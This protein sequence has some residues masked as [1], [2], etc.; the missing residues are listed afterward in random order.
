MDA[1]V[2]SVPDS[3]SI[4]CLAEIKTCI[5]LCEDL[6]QRLQLEEDIEAEESGVSCLKI[7]KLLP[8]SK[9]TVSKSLD[10]PPQTTHDES[11]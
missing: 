7:A 1:R 3:D 6:L 11:P 4:D 10:H 5:T 9:S 2:R 8:T